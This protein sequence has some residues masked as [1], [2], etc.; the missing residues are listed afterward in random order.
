MMGISLGVMPASTFA[1]VL[2]ERRHFERRDI[3]LP[4]LG[5]NDVC[6][7]N[8]VVAICGSDDEGVNRDSGRR[9]PSGEIDNE[10]IPG[11]ELAG[12]VVAIGTNVTKVQV[13]DRVA[14]DSKVSADP[15]RIIGVSLAGPDGYNQRGGFAGHYVAN[16]KGFFLLSE[17]MSYDEGAMIEPATV[18]M[19][20]VE[21]RANVRYGDSVVVIG[22]GPIGQFLTQI[23]RSNNYNC[24]VT[25]IGNHGWKLDLAR[26]FGAQQIFN[27]TEKSPDEILKKIKLMTNGGAKHVF[28]AVGK[29][30][31]VNLA[32]GAVLP[33]TG[34][35]TLLGNSAKEVMI[36]LQLVIQRELA[37]KASYAADGENRMVIDACVSGGMN[38]AAMITHKLPLSQVQRAF[39]NLAD[40]EWKRNQKVMKIAFDV[41]A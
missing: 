14:V 39:D 5:P 38:L 22:D 16:E 33:S 27:S 26:E 25:V 36:P 34:L 12:Q 9:Q 31:S 19:H 7:R 8:E 1:Y 2:S 6:I 28:E 13:G 3:A 32:L 15:V 40:P 20:A 29:Q 17:S 24:D 41:Y 35:I 4:V 23:L 37:M 11:H 10:T 18:A 30:D 21:T